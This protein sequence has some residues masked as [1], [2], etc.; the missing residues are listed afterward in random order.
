M[1]GWQ[2]G[3]ERDMMMKDMKPSERQSLKVPAVMGEVF[4]AD[5]VE[6]KAIPT[7]TEAIKIEWFRASH[8]N[9]ETTEAAAQEM[10]FFI[11]RQNGEELKEGWTSF[12]QTE[13]KVSPEKTSIGYMPLILSPAHVPLG[14]EPRDAAAKVT[15][16]HAWHPANVVQTA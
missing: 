5:V 13:S 6:G 11:K 4:P 2:R 15:T 7:S 1:A 8:D 10:A 16:C 3:P 14:A 12:N 9:K